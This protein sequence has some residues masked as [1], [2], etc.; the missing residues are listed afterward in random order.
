MIENW[1]RNLN[2]G[3]EIGI[4]FMDLCKAF[5]TLD[6]TLLLAKLEAYGFASLSLEYMKN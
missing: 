6:H 1:K 3:N 2:K 5:D 4:V